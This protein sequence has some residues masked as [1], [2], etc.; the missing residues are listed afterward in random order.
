MMKLDGTW[1]NELNSKMTLEVSGKKITGKYN[2]K[3]GDAE[4]EYDLIGQVDTDKDESQAI[5]W[6]VVWS[7]EK[8][9]NSDAVTAWS[10]QVQKVNGTVTIIT[11]WLLTGETDTENNWRS[12]RI[13]KDVFTQKAPKSNEIETSQKLGTNPSSPE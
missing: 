12:T 6:V 8:N 9:G 4:G 10:G 13:G 5:G 2:T 3:V 11:T 1:Y 7:N